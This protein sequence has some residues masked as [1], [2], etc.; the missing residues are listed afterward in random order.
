M[1]LIFIYIFFL[2]RHTNF[3]VLALKSESKK[4]TYSSVSSYQKPIKT[5]CYW[6]VAYRYA[7]AGFL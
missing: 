4:E 7:S 5:G 6:D 2:K 1:A 3:H